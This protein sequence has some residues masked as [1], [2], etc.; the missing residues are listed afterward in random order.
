MSLCHEYLN[1]VGAELKDMS[2]NLLQVNLE[3]QSRT[4][5]RTVSMSMVDV[6]F[7][8]AFVTAYDIG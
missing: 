4:L 7:V 8:K 1:F 5:W 2:I 6:R 3:S